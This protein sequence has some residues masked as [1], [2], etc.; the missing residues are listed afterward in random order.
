MAARDGTDLR[1]VQ[2]P[3]GGTAVHASLESV[4]V[5]IF[6]KELDLLLT[7]RGLPALLAR[8]GTAK[9]CDDLIYALIQGR[10]QVWGRME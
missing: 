6:G 7:F 4:G 9:E 8:I 2:L 5:Q 10:Q 3:G 1:S